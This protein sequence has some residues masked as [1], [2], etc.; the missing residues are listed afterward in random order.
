MWPHQIVSHLNRVD[1]KP[2]SDDYFML[3]LHYCNRERIHLIRIG[4]ITNIIKIQ[5]VIN[6]TFRG[7]ICMPKQIFVSML[8]S[9]VH[10]GYLLSDI[11]LLM[12]D[13]FSNVHA[14]FS[15]GLLSRRMGDVIYR[16]QECNWICGDLI[17]IQSIFF[18]LFV[19][20]FH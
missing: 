11:V 7:K 20:T 19:C 16:D 8:A 14:V 3:V 15:S 6:N 9:M 12:N 1:K 2:K 18:Y 5:Y 10:C 4:P 17:T 13:G